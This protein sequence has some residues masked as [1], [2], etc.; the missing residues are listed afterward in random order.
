MWVE[1]LLIQVKRTF[2]HILLYDAFSNFS[3]FFFVIGDAKRVSPCTMCTC[4]KEGPLCQSLKVENCFHLAQSFTRS[5]IL[6]DHVCKV[7]CAFAFRAFP[8]VRT[9]ENRI[10]FS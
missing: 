1:P 3:P 9:G 2:C 5:A 6:D 4:T 10:G 7:Q 8:N